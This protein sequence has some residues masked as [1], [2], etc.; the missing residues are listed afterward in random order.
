MTLK[1][2]LSFLADMTHIYSADIVFQLMSGSLGSRPI[3]YFLPSGNKISEVYISL[4]PPLA[5]MCM[6]D[7][8]FPSFLLSQM[9]F[10]P[11]A[12]RVTTATSYVALTSKSNQRMSE[13]VRS[14][15][16]AVCW[17]R[18]SA[19]CRLFDKYLPRCQDDTDG[20]PQ[21]RSSLGQMY[22]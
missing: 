13:N 3:V 20:K 8:V 19:A 1:L 21:G 11:M 2:D 6:G 22:G 9:V 18:A 16:T 4:P 14:G 5:L 12:T 7:T 17:R 15:R 10:S